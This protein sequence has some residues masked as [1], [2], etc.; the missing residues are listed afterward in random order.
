VE[1][2]LRL[3]F[4]MLS[5]KQYP[6]YF[7][8][9]S[10]IQLPVPKYKFPEE[11]KDASRLTY[12]STYFNSIEINSSF[13]KIPM[14]ATIARWR[15]SVHDNFRFTFKLFREI[16]HEKD[17]KYDP[18]LIVKFLEAI[19]HAGTKNGC[20]LVQLP[21]KLTNASTP[22]LEQL[23]NALRLADAAG[24]WNIAVEFRHKSWYTNE[25]YDILEAYGC[26]LVMQ[27]MP[28]CATPLREN[29][30]SVTYVRFHGPT[31]NYR[32]SYTDDFLREYAEYIQEWLKHG[33]T[34]Y[35]YFN[36][37]AGQAFDNLTTLNR[38][39]LK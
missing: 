10:G 1:Q 18:G 8:G 35:V 37:T 9:L 21:P 26:S 15:T 19:A 32:G 30:S 38:L 39:I 36:N 12:Y 16:T 14:P 29:T 25:T 7:S 33:K 6:H 27:D 4:V 22:R 17:L 11:Y 31:G 13:Y 3:E 28:K 2:F 34:V 23:L 20:I 24:L 5:N